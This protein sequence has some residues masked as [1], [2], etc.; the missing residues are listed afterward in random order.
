MWPALL[1]HSMA[2]GRRGGTKTTQD[3]TGNTETVSIFSLNSS[4]CFSYT[5][6]LYTQ[7][8]SQTHIFYFFNHWANNTCNIFCL[9]S[10]SL[11]DK[12]MT[13]NTFAKLSQGSRLGCSLCCS[14]CCTLVYSMLSKLD[15]WLNAIT[16][17]FFLFYKS[18]F[19]LSRCVRLYR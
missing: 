2:A 17:L 8:Y 6:L 3:S 14:S 11:V 1:W 5:A 19:I 9:L 4:L 16:F 15:K 12:Y 18:E 13:F 7:W 10:V